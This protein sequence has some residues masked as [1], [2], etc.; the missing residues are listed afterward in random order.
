MGL[1]GWAAGVVGVGGV[2]ADFVGLGCTGYSGGDS[3]T[4]VAGVG[5]GGRADA[6]A[7][8]QRAGHGALAGAVSGCYSRGV[9]GS[10]G[11]SGRET[12]RVYPGER[13][14]DSGTSGGHRGDWRSAGCGVGGRIS[15]GIQAGRSRPQVAHQRRSRGAPR[16]Y[17]HPVQCQRPRAGL[18]RNCRNAPCLRCRRRG[19]ARWGV[20]SRFANLR[21]RRGNF[22]LG[23]GS[24]D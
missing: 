13:L 17:H 1:A 18:A 20:D 21:I 8:A 14:F 15:A 10:A 24:V 23:G 4:P 16:I 6:S 9:E 3:A 11:R 5:G 12:Q 22:S 19:N 2:T 7:A